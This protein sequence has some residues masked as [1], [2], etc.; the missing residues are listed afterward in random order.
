MTDDFDKRWGKT[1]KCD[2]GVMLLP[3]N[4]LG[5]WQVICV[6]CENVTTPPE[7]LKASFNKNKGFEFPYAR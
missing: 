5:H 3:N 1:C 7:D 4:D 6:K 2:S